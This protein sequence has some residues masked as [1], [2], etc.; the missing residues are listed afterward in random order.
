MRLL[1]PNFCIYVFVLLF[2]F[3][4]FSDRRSL[5][6]ENEKENSDRKSQI[7]RTRVPRVQFINIETY[8]GWLELPLIRTYFHGPRLFEPLKIYCNSYLIM[9]FLLFINFKVN[10]IYDNEKALAHLI[11]I[12]THKKVVP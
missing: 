11:K 7:Y 4:I 1:W 9:A 10:D 5:K 8:P 3:S 6:I 2:S 12:G